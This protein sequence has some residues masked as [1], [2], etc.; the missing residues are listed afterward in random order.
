MTLNSEQTYFIA[1]LLTVAIF[2][3]MAGTVLAIPFYGF[4]PLLVVLAA[5]FVG[6]V[7]VKVLGGE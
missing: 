6:A 1:R 7:A 4:A 3:L 2:S 5:F